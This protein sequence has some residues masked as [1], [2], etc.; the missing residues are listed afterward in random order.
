ML[1][2]GL[3]KLQERKEGRRI[4]RRDPGRRGERISA[5]HVCRA[6]CSGGS[7]V[8]CVYARRGLPFSFS[9]QSRRRRAEE[10]KDRDKVGGAVGPWLD[11]GVRLLPSLP[12]L[13]LSP[14]SHSTLSSLSPF[15]IFSEPRRRGLADISEIHSIIAGGGEEGR[16]EATKAFLILSYIPSS[17]SLFFRPTHLFRRRCRHRKRESESSWLCL[18]LS[19]PWPLLTNGKSL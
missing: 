11:F 8:S 6:A 9:I 1:A 3:F 2:G 19:L 4:W 7:V 14:P 5:T 13:A 18:S 17:L 12:A 15:W 10:K 16:G